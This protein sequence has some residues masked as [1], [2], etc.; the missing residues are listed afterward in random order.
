MGCIGALW[1]ISP[2]LTLVM[3]VVIPVI[4]GGGSLMGSGLRKMSR[5]AQAQVC[6][7]ILLISK[8]I[9]YVGIHLS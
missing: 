1:I 3:C 2:K 5:A 7:H 9:G 8:F 6:I 4:I